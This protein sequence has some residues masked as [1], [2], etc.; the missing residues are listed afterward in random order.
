MLRRRRGRRGSWRACTRWPT[1]PRATSSPRRSSRVMAARRAS[2]TSGST[3]GPRRRA[4]ERR[5]PTIVARCRAAGIDPVTEPIPVAPGRA[6]RLRRAC[7]PTCPAAPP[8]PASTPAAR[9]PA[10]ACTAPTG[11]RPTAARGPGVRRPHRRRRCSRPAGR[12]PSPCPAAE[13]AGLLDPAVRGELRAVMTEGAGVLRSAPAWRRAGKALQSL[14]ERTTDVPD[15]RG[16]EATDLLAVAAALVAAAAARGDPRL[17]LARGLPAS[18]RP[19]CC[20]HLVSQRTRRR[21]EHDVRVRSHDPLSCTDASEADQLPR[22]LVES[23]VAGGAG[24]GSRRWRRRHQRGDGPGRHARHRAASS[25]AATASSPA[26]RSRR[27]RSTRAGAARHARWC[28]DGARVAPGD[29][30]LAVR[31]P[32]RGAADRRAHRAQPAVPPVRRRHR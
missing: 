15:P 29:A 27:S 18:R 9:S 8:C 30:V 3:R 21:P 32:V 24:R 16:W 7:A 11:W 13:P 19:R 28:A 26:C 22:A 6:L 20:G 1:W 14:S 31:G 5:F 25:P 4:L 12:R 17:P 2:T 23:L 10:P